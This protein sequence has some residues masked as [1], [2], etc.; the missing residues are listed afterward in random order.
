LKNCHRH[1]PINFAVANKAEHSIEWIIWLSES[2]IK[3]K[4]KSQNFKELS[5]K[6]IRKKS[7]IEE[8]ILFLTVANW[9][10]TNDN[11]IEFEPVSNETS[12]AD[13]KI[14]LSEIKI[15]LYIEI[16]NIKDDKFQQTH[17]AVS[18]HIS[19]QIT[20]KGLNYAGRILKEV[21]NSE[22]EIIL[23]QIT[24]GINECYNENTF[25]KIDS[26]MS[27][28]V[29]DFGFAPYAIKSEF[30][31]CSNSNNLS[32]SQISGPPAN[33]NL[34]LAKS[35]NR[36]LKEEAKQI[37]HNE[38]GL[39]ILNIGIVYFLYLDWKAIA[40]YMEMIMSSW[41]YKNIIGVMLI[42]DTTWNIEKK[43][44]KHFKNSVFI[45]APLW[46]IQSRK[47]LYS[48]NPNCTI[49]KDKIEYI[50]SVVKSIPEYNTI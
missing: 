26:S 21:E 12:K 46:G 45:E 48:R 15:D 10:A 8:G 33:T 19:E 49:K 40:E 23:K 24:K 30:E 11:L 17:G 39:I 18:W 37:Q 47:I 3:T 28:G 38:A 36:R 4:I 29:L 7:A 5:K 20:K 14:S 27:N 43:N 41:E 6:I 50:E 1:H 16:S 35:L 32:N 44:V 22:L 34:S 42:N 2:L 9:F 25:V 13:I 31:Q